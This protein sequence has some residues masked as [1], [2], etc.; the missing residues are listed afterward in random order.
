MATTQAWMRP[1]IGSAGGLNAV[2]ALRD[3]V[4]RRRRA[5]AGRLAVLVPAFVALC[6]FAGIRADSR[7]P[8]SIPDQ[9]IV[10]S[11]RLRAN[12]VYSRT[13]LPPS[14]PYARHISRVSKRYGIPAELLAAVV[15][16]ESR[17]NPRSV[18]P[19]GAVGLM[20]LLPTTA[21]PLARKLG[22]RQYDLMDPATNLELGA[23][24]LRDRIRHYGGDVHA[25]LSYYNGGRWG[26]VSRGRYRNRGYIRSVLK[27]YRRF[28][29]ETVAIVAA[30][31]SRR[32]VPAYN[33]LSAN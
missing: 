10:A 20:Q 8:L 13:V 31:P 11:W 15:H 14:Y 19:K 6:V 4:D 5:I 33:T 2:R 17:F 23:Y 24:F 7:P 12:P 1:A 22:F 27:E 30:Q 18:S 26:V 21:R 32:A 16:V 9:A 29:L 28:D 25:A 3:L